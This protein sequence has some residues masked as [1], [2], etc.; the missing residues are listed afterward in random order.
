MKVYDD[1]GPDL[2]LEYGTIRPKKQSEE[3]S[4]HM[5]PQY[6]I[7][8]FYD[9]AKCSTVINGK[10]YETDYPMA[11]ITA[12]YCMHFTNFIESDQAEVRRYVMY[13]EESFITRF[14][15]GVVPIKSILGDSSATIINLRGH[16]RRMKEITE[17]MMR[18]SGYEGGVLK[19]TLNQNLMSAVIINMLKDFSDSGEFG[20]QISEKNY[21]TDVMI[22]IVQNMETDLLIPKIADQFFVSRDKLCRDFR[23]HVQMNIGDFITAARINAA[24]NYLLENTRTIKEVAM[25][26]GFENDIYFYSF[27]KK[28]VGMTPKEY[29]RV[30]LRTSGK[31]LTVG[32]IRL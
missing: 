28:H 18:F 14:G 13:F 24:K 11:L 23:K 2:I 10:T 8:W 31:G 20:I 21:I 3:A 9:D 12:P 30:K 32:D 5:H 26:C 4:F 29:A 16:E 27:F 7:L 25:K 1:F 19:A 6:E 17:N 15:E 22:Y